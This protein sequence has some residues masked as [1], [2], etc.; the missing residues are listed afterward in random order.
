MNDIIELTIIDPETG[1]TM[2]PETDPEILSDVY[3]QL[4]ERLETLKEKKKTVKSLTEVSETWRSSL[5]YF[6]LISGLFVSLSDSETVFLETLTEDL[7]YLIK[8][9]N[10]LLYSLERLT[11]TPSIIWLSLTPIIVSEFYD[12][13]DLDDLNILKTAVIRSDSVKDLIGELTDRLSDSRDRVRKILYKVSDSYSEISDLSQSLG[14]IPKIGDSDHG[15]SLSEIVS[16]EDRV[17]R[18]VKSLTETL[19]TLETVSDLLSQVSESLSLF[20]E[21]IETRQKRLTVTYYLRK[22]LETAVIISESLKEKTGSHFL[23]SGGYPKYDPK[24]GEYLGSSQGYG[25]HFERNSLRDFESEDRVSISLDFGLEISISLYHF[26]RDC[27]EYDPILDCLFLEYSETPDKER[28]SLFGLQSDFTEDLEKVFEISG[29]YG[30]SEKMTV[31]TY[32]HESLL[33]QV[34]QYVYMT[35]DQETRIFLSIHNGSDVRGGYTRPVMYKVSDQYDETRIFDDSRLYISCHDPETGKETVSFYTDDSYHLYNDNDDQTLDLTP[36][37]FRTRSSN[38]KTRQKMEDQTERLSDLE[39]IILDLF[40]SGDPEDPKSIETLTRLLE[41]RDRLTKDLETLTDRH[42]Y[43]HNW[44]LTLSDF[45]TLDPSDLET[46][47]SED[48]ADHYNNSDPV[49]YFDRERPKKS[50]ILSGLGVMYFD[51]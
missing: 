45:R 37:D 28:E 7:E 51:F 9:S 16:L 41:I 11:E 35:L 42:K 48:L 30:E 18:S 20:S 24:T 6:S 39:S 38:N 49:I 25:R 33:S 4:T 2:T 44:S 32:N 14:I 27:L 40:T 3:N 15:I 17:S 47:D 1:Q 46:M 36:Y 23:D 29:L 22:D 43:G 34:I 19:E 31:N 21:D 10:G 50:P 12:L 5:S 13:E 26:L 8:E